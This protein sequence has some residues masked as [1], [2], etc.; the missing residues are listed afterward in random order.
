[1]GT[2]NGTLIGPFTRAGADVSGDIALEFRSVA[3]IG[4]LV[5]FSRVV[6]A[7]VLS[8]T[9]LRIGPIRTPFHW[10]FVLLLVRVDEDVLLKTIFGIGPIPTPVP[11]AFVLLLVGVDDQML[12]QMG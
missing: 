7:D 11:W 6:D 10:A 9:T 8:K 12:L 3:T 2:L 1:M 4:T 5:L